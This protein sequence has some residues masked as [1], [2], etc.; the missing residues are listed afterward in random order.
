MFSVI[1]AVETHSASD[2]SFGTHGSKEEVHWMQRCGETQTLEFSNTILTW[3]AAG[4][5][6]NHPEGLSWW[7]QLRP[8]AKNVA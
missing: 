2:G 8:D 6:R 7:W 1:V 3:R 5:Q 4:M